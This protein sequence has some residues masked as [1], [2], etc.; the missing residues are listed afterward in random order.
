MTSIYLNHYCRY[1]YCFFVKY[2]F[3]SVHYHKRIFISSAKSKDLILLSLKVKFIR[4]YGRSTGDD[5][6]LKD[7]FLSSVIRSIYPYWRSVSEDFSF[8]IRLSVMF[9]IFI[10]PIEVEC[11][12]SSAFYHWLILFLPFSR[13]ASRLKEV[14][15]HI[16]LYS[17]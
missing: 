3:S 17:T 16:S 8:I 15:A 2:L 5:F 1:P 13:N 6:Y 9:S 4:F 14:I 12:K 10:E 11:L 7:L